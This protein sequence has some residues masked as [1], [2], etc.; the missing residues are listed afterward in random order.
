MTSRVFAYYAWFLDAVSIVKAHSC[1]NNFARALSLSHSSTPPVNGA[2]RSLFFGVLTRNIVANLSQSGAAWLILLFLP[3]LLVR[4]LDRQTY[5]TWM[6]LLQLAAYITLIDTGI[7]T[8]IAR[9]VARAGGLG[10]ENY[11]GNLLSSAGA[12]LLA[13]GALASAIVLIVAWQL[14]HLFRSIP[15]PL[16]SDSRNALVLL[17]WSLALA[18]PFST[19]A[20]FFRGFQRNEIV[21]SSM[22]AGKFLG[23]VGIALAAYRHVG[24]TAMAAWNAAGNLIA[25]AA[26]LVIWSRSGRTAL[27]AVSRVTVRVARE[28][29]TFCSAMLVSQLAILLITGLDMPIVVAF[30]FRSAAYYAVATTAS[31][32][33][34]APYGAILNALLPVAANLSATNSPE[35]MGLALRKMTRYGTAILVLLTLPLMFEMNAFLRLWVGAAYAVQAAP[36]A[37]MLVAAQFIRLSMQPYAIVGFSVGQQHRMLV[38][39]FVE[40]I[41]NLVCSLIFVWQFGAMGVAFGTLIGAV[42]GISLHF[43]NSIPRTDAILIRR[44]TLLIQDIGRPIAFALPVVFLLCTLRVFELRLIAYL[45]ILSAGEA[46]VTMAYLCYLVEKHDREELVDLCR[47]IG[48][49]VSRRFALSK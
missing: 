20:G 34:I 17:G 19:L 1:D 36:L 22:V 42:L 2:S 43:F 40:G 24:L 13:A 48:A 39:P 18:L 29:L 10:D 15:G 33:L 16:I 11:M 8:A 46:A 31:N 7:Q 9:F 32:M 41:V 27:L 3:P 6:L 25:P 4:V 26:Y 49:L 23:A 14:P 28:F 5:A 47:R 35:R 45:V 12:V 21:A 37:E 44:R 30:D 38:S